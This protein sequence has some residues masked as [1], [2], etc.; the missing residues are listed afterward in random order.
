MRWRG[1]GGGKFGGGGWG[2]GIENSH[3]E[4]CTQAIIAQMTCINMGHKNVSVIE[5]G[6]G[7]GAGGAEGE[8][9]GGGGGR[10]TRLSHCIY[11]RF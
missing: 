11:H 10:V 1:G 5:Q 2:G 4:L 6:W 3:S 7:R 8:V 9:G